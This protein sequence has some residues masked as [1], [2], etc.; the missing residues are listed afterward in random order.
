[1]RNPY[2]ERVPLELVVAVITDGGIMPAADVP[3]FCA[4]L[5]LATPPGLVRQ[6]AE[7]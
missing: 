7:R 4:S 3:A 6:L 1:V 5:E 2:F